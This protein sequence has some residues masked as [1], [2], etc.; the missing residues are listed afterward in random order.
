ME[1]VSLTSEQ[2]EFNEIIKNV[3]YQLISEEE[4]NRLFEA[5]KDVGYFQVNGKDYMF[6]IKHD[7]SIGKTETEDEP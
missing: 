6:R 5:E 4:Y 7:V 3:N 2:L 1:S